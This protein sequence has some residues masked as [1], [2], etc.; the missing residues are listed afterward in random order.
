MISPSL[1]LPIIRRSSSS[2]RALRMVSPIL[3][4]HPCTTY[5]NEPPINYVRARARWKVLGR[6]CRA[7]TL[8]EL[9]LTSALNATSELPRVNWISVVANH[10]LSRIRVLSRASSYST[11]FFTVITRPLD[12]TDI[13]CR[14]RHWRS[15]SGRLI[16]ATASAYTA[17]VFRSGVNT[18]ER[19]PGCNNPIRIAHRSCGPRWDF[20]PALAKIPI[21]GQHPST[22]CQKLLTR[23]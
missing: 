13:G 6:T 22:L 4:S 1:F 3:T 2:S 18:R 19:A 15:F 9:V 17:C 5:D 12:R 7:P 20:E 11:S 14:S 21:C 10:A 8:T 16:A 23:H